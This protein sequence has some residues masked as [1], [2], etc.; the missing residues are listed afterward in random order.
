MPAGPSDACRM[1]AG[2]GRSYGLVA[3]LFA[4]RAVP[5]ESADFNVGVPVDA[6]ATIAS[7]GFSPSRDFLAS[8]GLSVLAFPAVARL[9]RGRYFSAQRWISSL[10]ENCRHSRAS[11]SLWPRV[12]VTST[13]TVEFA[14]D[15]CASVVVLDGSDGCISCASAGAAKS[16]VSAAIHIERFMSLLLLQSLSERLGGRPRRA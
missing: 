12:S 3:P 15:G 16:T 14:A 11:A 1:P 10:P 13:G 5:S 2:G 4:M 7:A 8:D 6:A 9:T